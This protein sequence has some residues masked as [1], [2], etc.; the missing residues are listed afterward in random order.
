MSQDKVRAK[1]A[2]CQITESGQRLGGSMLQI[3]T[4]RVDPEVEIQK[5]RVVGEARNR[6]DLDVKGIGF[7]F[8]A[9]QRDRVWFD[10][11]RRIMAADQ[12]GRP[13]PEISLA[14][15]VAHR[16]G[17]PLTF[18]LHGDLVMHLSPW[19]RQNEGYVTHSWTGYCSF[20]DGA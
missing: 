13:F 10:L 17:A 11:W 14:I 19:E 3:F 4:L 16:V 12:N 9:Y 5:T 15:S 6:G 20:M 7:T 8:Q 1:E 2:T 18:V